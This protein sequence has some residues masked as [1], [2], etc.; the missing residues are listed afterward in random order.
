MG[1]MMLAAGLGTPLTIRVEG[2]D[3]QLAITAVAD[4]FGRKFDEGA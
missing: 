4:L 3:E 1:V 2:V